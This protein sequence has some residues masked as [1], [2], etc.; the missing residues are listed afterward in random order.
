MR[1]AGWSP[2]SSKVRLA[3][4]PAIAIAGCSIWMLL[5]QVSD[6]ESGSPGDAI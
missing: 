4:L 2:G 5:P 1:I 3:V 6:A